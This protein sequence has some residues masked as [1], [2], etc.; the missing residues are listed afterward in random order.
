MEISTEDYLMFV[1]RALD[2]MMGIVEEMG[3]ALANS[4]PDL[5]NLKQ[6]NSPYAILFHC[7]GVYHYWVG[8]LVAG[9]NTDRDRPAEF[10]ASGSVADLKKLVSALKLQFR[11][12]LN[13]VDGGQSLAI[14]PNPDY[15]P[16]PGYTQWTQG[17][18]LI[19]VYEE[20]AQHHGQMELTRDILLK[21]GF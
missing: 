18:V 15:T 6:A 21:S 16:L 20:L 4:S 8:T 11:T 5:P 13:S 7:V 9:R 17:A 14:M 19:H 1:D 2:G 12:D 3:D 10:I